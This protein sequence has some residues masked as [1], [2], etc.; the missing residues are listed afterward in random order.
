MRVILGTFDSKKGN[1]IFTVGSKENFEALIKNACD[2]I[3]RMYIEE[4]TPIQIVGEHI[5]DF[6]LRC[7]GINLSESIGYLEDFTIEEIGAYDED[8]T[9][10]IFELS[11]TVVS[12]SP[13]INADTKFSL[14]SIVN[15]TSKFNHVIEI[16]TWD[17]KFDKSSVDY[18]YATSLDKKETMRIDIYG[19]GNSYVTDQVSTVSVNEA[20]LNEENRIKFVTDLAAVSRGNSESKNP[21]KRYQALLKEAAPTDK[22]IMEIYNQNSEKSCP[23]LAVDAFKDIQG[24]PSKPMEFLPV[25]LDY[26]VSEGHNGAGSKVVI[27]N[28]LSGNKSEP[29]EY[30]NLFVFEFEDYNNLLGQHS[31]MKNGHI[32]TN[33]RAV[34]NAGILYKDIPYNTKED[35]KEF[36]ALKAMVPLMV[37]AQVPQTHTKLS[38][39]SQSDRVSSNNKYWLPIDFRKRVYDY[40]LKHAFEHKDAVAQELL[41][42]EGKRLTGSY[43]FPIY[44]KLTDEILSCCD[45]DQ[46]P[47]IMVNGNRATDCTPTQNE[48][49][50]YFK[51]LGYHQ[52]IYSRAMYYF[53]YKEVVMTG[54][55]NDPK[56]WN[57]LFIER[58]AVPEVW[59]NWTQNETKLFVEAMKKI[60]ENNMLTNISTN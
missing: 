40:K 33:M 18:T 41:E 52:E 7:K 14:R 42:N 12:T 23:L 47:Y 35:L 34:L 27:T 1:N 5:E 60:V 30:D 51:E 48:V 10:V 29:E 57:H 46:V 50:M 11:A 39:E 31:Y 19:D 28:L 43:P 37:W 32:Y 6:M 53:K 15:A 2:D 17:L 24:S 36:R 21:A 45:K 13:L 4:Y 20:N 16:I 25:V 8:P 38:K 59:Q 54:W 56:V 49:Q 55:R 3:G 58:S 9:N 44:Q 26:F 22:S